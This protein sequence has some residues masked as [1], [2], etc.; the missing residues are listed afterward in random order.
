[1]S[2]EG[3]W[4]IR[5]VLRWTTSFF[6]EKGI[7]GARLDAE[8]IIADALGIG[9]IQIYTDHDRPLHPEELAA[10][11]ERVRRRA[12]REPV[13]YILGRRG[14]RDLELTVDARVLI[15]RPETE[16]VV[17]VALARLTGQQAPLVVD[18]GTGSGAIALAIAE[19]RPDAQVV[20]I[21]ASPDALAVARE[22]ATRLGL[23]NVELLQGDLLAPLGERQAHLIASNPP[24]IPTAEVARLMPD[25]RDYEPRL[26]LDGGPDGL[27]VI[28]RLLPAAAARLVPGG[29]LV[30]EIG[31][32]QGPALRRLLADGWT[33]VHVHADLAGHDRVV[34]ATKA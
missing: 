14:F 19:A 16:L 5:R 6:G 11:R 4:T 32:D 15:P 12:R 29:A 25:V 10:I 3:P 27:S 24:Y 13:A 26:A 21:D 9:R 30:M 7:E 23:A 28:R 18:V 17:D 34:E 20:A 8:L 22:N 31:Y 33:G 1:M 2:D